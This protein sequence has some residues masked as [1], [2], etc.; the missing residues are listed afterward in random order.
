MNKRSLSQRTRPGK[1]KYRGVT[2]NRRA[3]KWQACIKISG[4]NKHFGNFEEELDGLM[5]VNEAYFKYFPDNPELQQ[6]N[7]KE[8]LLDLNSAICGKW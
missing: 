8:K 5:A 2:W 4:K 7:Q 3:G 1:N 6:V